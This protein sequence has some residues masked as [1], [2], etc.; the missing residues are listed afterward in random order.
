MVFEKR[1]FQYFGNSANLDLLDLHH[2][3]KDGLHTA[4]MG[5][6]YM[7]I[8][9]GFGGF[10]LKESGIHFSPILPDRWEGY[11]FRICYENSRI[12]IAVDQKVCS[13]FLEYGDPKDVFVY[14][15]RYRLENLL[16]IQRPKR[17]NKKEPGLGHLRKK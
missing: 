16:T 15:T 4:N 14:D 7:A 6:N 13:F 1:A 2:N 5:G 3:S 11:R 8:V 9:Y 10:R 12:I 17:T